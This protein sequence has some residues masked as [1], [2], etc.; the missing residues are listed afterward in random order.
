M[1]ISYSG[2]GGSGGGAG[3]FGVGSKS[4]INPHGLKTSSLNWLNKYMQSQAPQSPQYNP[5]GQRAGNMLS[6]GSSIYSAGL[7]DLISRRNMKKDYRLNRRG[8]ELTGDEIDIDKQRIGDWQE[9]LRKKK[10]LY[11]EDLGRRGVGGM[12]R[13]GKSAADWHFENEQSGINRATKENK[14]AGKRNE[15]ATS[16]NREAKNRWKRQ[17][18][19]NIL[20]G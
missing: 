11:N 5:Y 7:R 8:I 19:Y 3:P 1:G 18:L 20:F 10:I 16:Q 13:E 6:F 9:Y 12:T 15:L 17:R 4:S 14:L 2:G